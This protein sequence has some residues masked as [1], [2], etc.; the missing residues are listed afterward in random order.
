VPQFEYIPTTTPSESFPEELQL[1][2]ATTCPYNLVTIP[3]YGPTIYPIFRRLHLL[4]IATSLRWKAAR[5][6]SIT[7]RVNVSN[8]LLDV[9]YDM[10]TTSARFTQDQNDKNSAVDEHLIAV[11]DALVTAAQIFLF[12]SLRSIPMG[13]RTVEIFLTRIKIAIK[14]ENLLDTWDKFAS[15]HAL[16]WTLFISAA[17]STNRPQYSDIISELK[18]VMALLD[19][20]TQ[21]TLEYHLL[22]IAWADFFELCSAELAKELFTN[23]SQPL[24]MD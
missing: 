21:K 15:H 20:K 18:A 24:G 8:M 4:G 17:A 10:L 1:E 13:A 5:N 2:T 19:I 22:H 7:L 9:E 11:C 23:H 3:T 6:I 12:A 16:L 14:R